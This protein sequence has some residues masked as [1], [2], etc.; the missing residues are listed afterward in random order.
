V[1]E[2]HDVGRR[3]S[4]GSIPWL[5][6]A[7]EFVVIFLGVTISLVAD[8]WRIERQERADESLLLGEFAAELTADSIGLVGYQDRLESF[9]RWVGWVWLHLGDAGVEADSA[10]FRIRGLLSGARYQPRLATYVGTRD[11]GKLSLVASASLRRLIVDY[12][13]TQQ[14]A[15]VL[16]AESV[17]EWRETHAGVALDHVTLQASEGRSSLW[18]PGPLE[19]MT[20]WNE[21]RTDPRLRPALMNLGIG[22]GDRA[23]RVADVLERNAELRDAITSALAEL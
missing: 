23:Q 19:F 10:A 20:S 3:T 4:L 15:T 6:I 13:E 11:A 18:P 2:I 21:Y 22:S 9:D 7:A 14:A 17:A 1:S 12:Y 5:R 8:D 16:S